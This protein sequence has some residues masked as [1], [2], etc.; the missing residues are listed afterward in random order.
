MY[1][2]RKPSLNPGLIFYS[3]VLLLLLKFQLF[4]FLPIIHFERMSVYGVI[5]SSNLTSTSVDAQVFQKKSVDDTLS[6]FVLA[7]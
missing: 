5:Q 7:F 3:Y 2:N 6:P 4:F 1:H